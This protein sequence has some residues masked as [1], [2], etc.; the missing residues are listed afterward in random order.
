VRLE[1]FEI[2]RGSGGAGA[3]RGG[4]GVVR[5][6]RALVPLEVSILSQ[7][8]TTRPFGLAGGESGAAGRTLIN[9]LEIPGSHTASIVAGDRITIETPGGGG[10]GRSS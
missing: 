1:R 9:D 8:R 5:E 2:R 7:R 6:L 3:Y 10:Y 4:D